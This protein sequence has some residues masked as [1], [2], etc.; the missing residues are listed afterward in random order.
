TYVKK[1]TDLWTEWLT[2]VDHKKIGVMY[3]IVDMVML[4]R[5]FADAIIMRTQLAMAN[6]G[7]PGYL[8]PERYDQI[9]TAHGVIMIIF[10]AMPF[11]TGLMN[12]AGPL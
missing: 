5:D 8:R 3:I 7:S 6:E 12:L 11:F 4:L 10:M 1:W 2:S 9:F